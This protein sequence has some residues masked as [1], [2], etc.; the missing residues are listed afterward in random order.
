[1]LTKEEFTKQIIEM[2]KEITTKYKKE[3]QKHNA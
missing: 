2:M 1:M 3:N